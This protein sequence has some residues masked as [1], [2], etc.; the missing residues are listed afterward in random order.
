MIST[1][2]KKRRQAVVLG[3]PGVAPEDLAGLQEIAEMLGVTKPTAYRYIARNDFPEPLGQISTGRVWLR[4]D[5]QRWAK[6]T[7]PLPTGRPR[8]EP[9]G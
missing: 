4:R 7:L 8:K 1:P 3:S 9:D 2:P 6:Q 5:V